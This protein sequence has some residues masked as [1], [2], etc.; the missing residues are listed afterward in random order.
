MRLL[1]LLSGFISEGSKASVMVAMKDCP[2]LQFGPLEYQ[3]NRVLHDPRNPYPDIALP[4]AWLMTN[5]W[6]TNF[7]AGLGGFHAFRFS[8]LAASGDDQCKELS[9]LQAVNSGFVSFRI[10]KDFQI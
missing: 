4:Y 1:F 7:A 8:V 10:G 5:Y 6:E 3:E 9:L 2:L